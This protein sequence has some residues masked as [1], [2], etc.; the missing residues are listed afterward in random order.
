MLM[1]GLNPMNNFNYVTLTNQGSNRIAEAILNGTKIRIIG[2]VGIT[3]EQPKK[4]AVQAM[5]GLYCNPVKSANSSE[6]SW[7]I[8]VE[9]IADKGTYYFR[10]DYIFVSFG[11]NAASFSTTKIYKELAILCRPD[12]EGEENNLYTFLVFQPTIPLDINS[13]EYQTVTT[14][15]FKIYFPNPESVFTR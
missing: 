6:G 11:Y 2:L 5:A 9:F 8:P 4:T 7:R 15:S 13:T 1:G 14:L 12:V 3:S 10:E